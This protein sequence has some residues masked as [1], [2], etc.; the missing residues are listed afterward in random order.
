MSGGGGTAPTPTLNALEQAAQLF[1]DYYEGEVSVKPSDLRA[2]TAMYKQESGRSFMIVGI[3]PNTFTE[4]PYPLMLVKTSS[5]QVCTMT[6]DDSTEPAKV[7][8][9]EIYTNP[10][11]ITVNEFLQQQ[12]LS[13][14]GFLLVGWVT[15]DDSLIGM[16][17]HPDS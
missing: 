13:K 15:E 12:S 5:D 16:E 7:D 17:I 6:I 4:T 14:Y 8:S 11:P 3:V 10:K 9:V 2:Y 1:T